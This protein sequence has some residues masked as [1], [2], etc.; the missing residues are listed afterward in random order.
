MITKVSGRD[1]KS[2]ELVK[3]YLDE[4]PADFLLHLMLTAWTGEPFKIKGEWWGD[5]FPVPVE[6]LVKVRSVGYTKNE[7]MLV[8]DCEGK[9][10]RVILEQG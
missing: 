10:V 4:E 8:L 6:Y 7:M 2:V 9:E 3:Y 1:L 5:D